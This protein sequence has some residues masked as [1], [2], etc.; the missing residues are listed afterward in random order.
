VTGLVFLFPTF[1]FGKSLQRGIATSG[2][3]KNVCAVESANRPEVSERLSLICQ[4]GNFAGI[5]SKFVAVFIFHQKL[6]GHVSGSEPD[7]FLLWQ[8]SGIGNELGVPPDLANAALGYGSVFPVLSSRHWEERMLVSQRSPLSD[9]PVER[10]GE[11][12]TVLEIDHKPSISFA[13]LPRD[14]CGHS[15][16]LVTDGNIG[17]LAN[18]Q[19]FSGQ[20]IGSNHRIPLTRGYCRSDDSGESDDN[21]ENSY[22]RVGMFGLLDEIPE[23]HNRLEWGWLIA[24]I[25]FCAISI[26]GIMLGWLSFSDEGSRLMLLKSIGYIAGGW[27]AAVFCLFHALDP[28]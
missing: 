25:V 28:Q 17:P 23:S 14:K 16:I 3:C 20:S 5:G 6:Q 22:Y 27:I 11:M 12:S 2:D 15:A 4:L 26:Y 1:A 13:V 7:D 18:F 9:P 21:R 10:R 24:G 19:R 8:F